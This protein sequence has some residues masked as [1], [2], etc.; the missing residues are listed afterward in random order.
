MFSRFTYRLLVL[1]VL[2]VIVFT[3]TGC[4]LNGSC[5]GLTCVS[6]ISGTVKDTATNGIDTMTDSIDA[7][8]LIGDLVCDATLQTSTNPACP[9][10]PGN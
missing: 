10:Y 5:K 3:L 1:L 8:S 7:N 6:G 2:L 4:D 9:D